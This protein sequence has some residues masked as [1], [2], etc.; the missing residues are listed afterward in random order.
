MTHRPRKS[1]PDGA[2][3]RRLHQQGLSYYKI[4][5]QLDSNYAAVYRADKSV[6]TN[7]DTS[8]SERIDSAP[9]LPQRVEM[10]GE[11][12]S[13]APAHQSALQRIDPAILRE[14]D[15]RIAV[16]EAFMAAQQQLANAPERISASAHPNALQRINP[17]VWVNRGTHIAQDMIER[18]KAYAH[19]HRLQMREVIDLALRRFF[20]GEGGHHA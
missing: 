11:P 8:A 4:A 15:S 16:L 7:G 12:V 13:D 20:A 1:K 2:E 10:V 5:E 6:L 18:I 19:E 9:T 17:P 14:Y 3:V